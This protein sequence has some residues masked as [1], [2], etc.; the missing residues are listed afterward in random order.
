MLLTE[1]MADYYKAYYQKF[2]GGGQ[3]FCSIRKNQND[4]ERI[5]LIYYYSGAIIFLYESA[6]AL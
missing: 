3:N 5:V 4:F 1:K 6:V 2:H